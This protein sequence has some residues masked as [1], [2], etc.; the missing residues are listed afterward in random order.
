MINKE[1]DRETFT[2]QTERQTNRVRE[3]ERQSK[4]SFERRECKSERV[5]N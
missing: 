4:R 1:R 2:G 5:S 3:G